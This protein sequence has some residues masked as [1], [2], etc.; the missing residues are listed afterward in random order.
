[1]SVPDTSYELSQTFRVSQE[2]LFNSFL[3]PAILKTIWGVSRITVDARPKDQARAHM[4]IADENWDFTITYQEVIPNEK[5]RWI[6]H[7]DR[8]PSKEIHAV[9][10]FTKITD[11]AK[12]TVQMD[13]FESIQERDANRSAWQGALRTLGGLIGRK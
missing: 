11:G 5:L 9:L 3:D 10:W 8:F 6:V 13:N 7:F 12:L 4:I 2:A 1:M